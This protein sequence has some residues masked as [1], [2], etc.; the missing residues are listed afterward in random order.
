MLGL[1]ETVCEAI[2]VL[3]L[4]LQMSNLSHQRKLLFCK[5]IYTCSLHNV[6][7]LSRLAYIYNASIAISSIYDVHSLNVSNSAIKGS[8]LTLFAA[9]VNP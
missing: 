6:V 5:N 3:F 8:I 1:V 4:L 9:S 2:A 7:L